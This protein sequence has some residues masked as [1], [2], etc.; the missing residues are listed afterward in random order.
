MTTAVRVQ[1]QQAPKRQV[2]AAAALPLLDPNGASVALG[3]VP[4][5]TGLAAP[6]V[7][8]EQSLFAPRGACVAADGCLW[9][10]DTGHHRMLGW[11]SLPTQDNEPATLLVGQASFRDEGRN[12][13]HGPGPATL[14]VPTGIAACGRG[15]AVA[16]AWNHR[17]LLWNESPTRSNQPADVVLGQLTW[18]AVESNR[19]SDTPCADTLFWPFGVA[20]DGARLWV[21]DTGNRRVLVWNGWP[22]QHGQKADLVLGQK[23]FDCRDENAGANPDAMSMRWPH[24][25]A[26]MGDRVCVT[27]AGNSRIMVWASTPGRDGAPC[28]AILGQQSFDS[29]DHNQGE[30]WPG[31]ST[32]NMPYSLAVSGDW[33]WVADTANSRLIAWHADQIRGCGA[34]AGRLTGQPNWD[35]KG[36]NRWSVATRDSLCWPYGVCADRTLA[37]VADAGNNRVLLW[38][39]NP[40]LVT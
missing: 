27:D 22:T 9:V 25:I 4:D 39:S 24:G 12:G 13:K 3:F 20:W 8:S 10:A 5:M 31:A 7:P 28:Q 37:I 17:V 1:I 30:Y 15:L 33:L 26:F 32:L 16:D 34:D 21:A 19:G 38:P 23:S 35:S 29:V 36:D 6:V 11:R 40:G 14:N 18:D 2:S